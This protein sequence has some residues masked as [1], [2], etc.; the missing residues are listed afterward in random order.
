M[1]VITV[2]EGPILKENDPADGL[3]VIKSGVAKVTK[4]ADGGGPEAVLNLLREG[5]SFGEIGLIDG[6]PRSANVA[7]MQPLE[8]YYLGRDDFFA[9][10]DRNPEMARGILRSLASMVRNADAW[11]A[12]AI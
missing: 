1:D 3:Y 7:A 2:P 9:L 10:L 11:V 8:Y 12:R 6:L 5:D 4:S